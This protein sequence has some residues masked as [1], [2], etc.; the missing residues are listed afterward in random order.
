MSPEARFER[1]RNNCVVTVTQ[2]SSF[3]M[4]GFHFTPVQEE[5]PRYVEVLI[6]RHYFGT[7]A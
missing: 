2:P 4:H 1:E 7:P 3:F 5:A 6:A